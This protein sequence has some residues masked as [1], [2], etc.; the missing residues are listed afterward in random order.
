MLS[1]LLFPYCIGEASIPKNGDVEDRLMVGKY[2]VSNPQFC[3]FSCWWGC[4]A[5]ACYLSFYL[6]ISGSISC[7]SGKSGVVFAILRVQYV[8]ILRRWKI[9]R[10]MICGMSQLSAFAWDIDVRG[11]LIK[12]CPP[13]PAQIVVSTSIAWEKRQTYLSE[14]STPEIHPPLARRV[15][16]SFVRSAPIST[17]YCPVDLLGRS[18]LRGRDFSLVSYIFE[19]HLLTCNPDKPVGQ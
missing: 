5:S 8:L 1:V 12:T 14:V 16:D 10:P 4:M 6:C 15:Y 9:M 7:W 17:N 13:S 11:R 3:G 18:I 19:T 2:A